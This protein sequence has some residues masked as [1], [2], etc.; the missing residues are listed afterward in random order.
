MTTPDAHQQVATMSNTAN[1]ATQVTAYSQAHPAMMRTFWACA[2]HHLPPEGLQALAAR[3]GGDTM[4]ES[5]KRQ[6]RTL[7]MEN[8]TAPFSLGPK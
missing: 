6:L 1:L 4:G 8:R 3:M 2:I 7:A 5:L